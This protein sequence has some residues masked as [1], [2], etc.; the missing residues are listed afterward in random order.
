MPVFN[1]RP[2]STNVWVP[3][4]RLTLHVSKADAVA[5]TNVRATVTAGKDTAGAQSVWTYTDPTYDI[6]WARTPAGVV[7]EVIASD[8]AATAR[9]FTLEPNVVC[10]GTTHNDPGFPWPFAFDDGADHTALSDA[11]F[12]NYVR[13]KYRIVQCG[14]SSSNGPGVGT[15]SGF[16]SCPLW[17]QAAD[18]SA[19]TVS[20]Q[21]LDGGV[22]FEVV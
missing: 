13:R 1:G 19:A 18:A 9:A 20:I 3:F 6:L 8:G 21:T 7:F 5:G 15:P 22:P 17:F 14:P 12:L 10:S 16:G 11:D 4:A 2:D